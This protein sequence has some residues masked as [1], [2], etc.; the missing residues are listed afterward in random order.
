MYDEHEE[1][2][3]RT[4]ALRRPCHPPALAPQAEIR[5]ALVRAALRIVAAVLLGGIHCD[6][7]RG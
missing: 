2:A 1:R 4:E 5:F 6:H 3:R 7:D